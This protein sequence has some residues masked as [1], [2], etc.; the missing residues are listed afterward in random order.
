M[1]APRPAFH[2]ASGSGWSMTSIWCMWSG[3]F[4]KSGN[5]DQPVSRLWVGLQ[6]LLHRY[7]GW[8]ADIFGRWVRESSWKMMVRATEKEGEEAQDRG[9]MSFCVWPPRCSVDYLEFAR[10]VDA[11]YQSRWAGFGWQA[12]STWRLVAFAQSN[13]GNEHRSSQVPMKLNYL[14]EKNPSSICQ[15]WFAV[16]LSPIIRLTILSI[17]LYEAV[18]RPF[19]QKLWL[20]YRVAENSEVINTLIAAARNSKQVTVF[21]ELGAFWWRK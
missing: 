2:R 9:G 8:V 14:D 12:S 4:I 5:A 20:R 19:L 21:V 3:D 18:H 17:F 7:R 6:L 1:I 16:T 13:R 10:L 15:R 11:G